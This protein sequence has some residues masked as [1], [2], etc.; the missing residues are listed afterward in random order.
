MRKLWFLFAFFF[1]PVLFAQV[2]VQPKI[3]M[4]PSNGTTFIFS[5]NLAA[6]FVKKAV[7]ASIVSDISEADYILQSTPVTSK[8]E[9]A[10]SVI[11]RCLF[12]YCAGAAGSNTV[13]IELIDEKNGLVVW[14]Y[15]V[16][17]AGSGNYQS[18]AEACAKHLKAWL[19]H[20][21]N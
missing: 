21:G 4:A 10:G 11:A 14:A 17:K 8:V 13:S 5:V 6:A 20:K 3:Y 1:A 9:S 2:P 12:L 19:E 7:P 18:S 16:K 15:T